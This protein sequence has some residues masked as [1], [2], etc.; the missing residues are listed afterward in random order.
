[1]HLT[2]KLYTEPK[3]SPA[4]PESSDMSKTWYVWFRFFDFTSHSWKQLRYKKEINEIK[5]FKERL[6]EANGLRQAIKEE[7]QDGWNPLTN[8]K[9]KKMFSLQETLDYI[10]ELKS[11]S[12]RPKSVVTY[13][14]I[15]K[16]FKDWLEENGRSNY[17]MGGF[18]PV[19]AQKYM[20]Q[21]ILRKNYSNRSHNDHL[22]ILSTFF[23]CM[24]AREWIHRNPFKGIKKKKAAVG[25][26]HA[27]TDHE[28]DQLRAVLIKND[29][30]LYYF[31]QVMYFTYIRRTE[32]T[33]LKVGDF[34]LTNNT[35][36]IRAEVSKNK[37][38]ESVVIPEGLDPILKQMGLEHYP[39]DHFVFGRHLFPSEQQYVN[40][41]HITTR[42]NK[43]VRRLQIDRQKGLYSWKHSGV[44]AAYYATGKDIYSLL[45]QLRHRDLT[46]TTIYL[47]SLGLVHNDVFRRSMVA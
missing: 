35:I 31:T 32:L 21:L 45:R 2:E 8:E 36:V 30:W 43:F 26:N 9:A 17:N 1:M 20:D 37:T 44:C 13:R 42:H 16:L 40:P 34:D 6:V 27:F 12:I 14:N 19:M 7:L 23:N 15:I 41:D 5:T 24:V 22:V 3:L 4:K 25:R 39:T 29:P 38:Q 28:K 18:T 10:L 47:K 33:K 46:T 11:K